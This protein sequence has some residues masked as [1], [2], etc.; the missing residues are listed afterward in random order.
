MKIKLIFIDVDGTLT[1]G[2]F[3][4]SGDSEV[5]RSFSI[6]DEEG[7]YHLMSDYNVIPVILTGRR[8]NDIVINRC[9][10]LGIT[11]YY[12]EVK[13]K[14]ELIQKYEIRYPHTAFAFIGD[15]TNDIPCMNYVRQLNGIIAC[16]ADACQEVKIIADY[17]CR[18]P[19]GE[20]AVR[21]FID[22]LIESESL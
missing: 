19:C 15:D 5:F 7:L 14:V 3:Y 11:D 20:G 13:D 1:D 4:L 18:Y 8:T 9:K 6:K 17:V 10:E 21:D 12:Q 16:P 2:K 22:Y